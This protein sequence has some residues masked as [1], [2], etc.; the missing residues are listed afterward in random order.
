MSAC[1]LASDRCYGSIAPADPRLGEVVFIFDRATS[2]YFG[3]NI[4]AENGRVEFSN[5]VVRTAFVDN[6]GQLPS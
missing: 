2:R 3:Y 6:I 1:R 4:L 5:A